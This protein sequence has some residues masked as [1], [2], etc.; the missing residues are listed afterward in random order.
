MKAE[1]RKQLETNVLADR[2]GRLMTDARKKPSGRSV[3]YMVL[4]LIILGV[5]VGWYLIHI[6]SLRTQSELWLKLDESSKQ[7][8]DGEILKDYRETRQGQI[9][10]LEQ[11]W[12]HLWEYG[13]KFMPSGGKLSVQLIQKSKADYQKLLDE[14]KEDPVLGAE[15]LYNIAVAEEALAAENLKSLDAARETYKRVKE[16]YKDSAFAELAKQR[17]AV[18]DNADT[19]KELEDFYAELNPKEKERRLKQKLGLE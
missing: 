10:R 6:T 5:G 18:F 7:T 17:L 15:A 16:E 14:V 11:S 4:A 13:I 8:I 19:R 1:H 2:M 9:A 12:L 3:L